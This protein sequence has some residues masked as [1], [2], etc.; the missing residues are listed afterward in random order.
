MLVGFA[1]RSVAG[2]S[3]VSF[4]AWAMRAGPILTSGAAT[5]AS[6][7]RRGMFGPDTESLVATVL[8]VPPTLAFFAA[9]TDRAHRAPFAADVASHPGIAL[10]VATV[11]LTLALA[12]PTDPVRA[13]L[14]GAALG[15]AGGSWLYVLCTMTCPSTALDH[16]LAVHLALVPLGALVGAVAAWWA[17]AF[18]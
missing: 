17:R 2:A 12:W 3:L 13:H 1:A 7:R 14:H 6:T 8:G 18:R 5:F 9:L 16:V 11:A 4:G 10:V 15:T